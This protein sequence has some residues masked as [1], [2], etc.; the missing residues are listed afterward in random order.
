MRKLQKITASVLCFFMI[1]S[2]TANISFAS[3]SADVRDTKYETQAQVLG[4]LGIM[5]GDAGTGAFRP[6]DPIKRSEA[7][8]IAIALMGL[9]A[10]AQSPQKSV[11][12]DVAD[13][14]S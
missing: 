10:S 8:K 5:V 2:M 13:D 9:F 12:P 14:L 3:V 7:S 1:L 6:N 11:F 4:G